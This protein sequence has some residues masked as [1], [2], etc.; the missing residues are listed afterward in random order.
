M[1]HGMLCNAAVADMVTLSAQCCQIVSIHAKMFAD[2]HATTFGMQGPDLISSML[3]SCLSTTARVADTAVGR[4][5][6]VLQSVAPAAAPRHKVSQ[7]QILLQLHLWLSSCMHISL[8]ACPILLPMPVT[9]LTSILE[10]H[11]WFCGV[12]LFAFLVAF[13]QPP[14]LTT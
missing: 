7:T 4:L 14:L 2:L 1:R 9:H 6:D 13:E 5:A 3:N 8:I 12:L 11:S 10:Q